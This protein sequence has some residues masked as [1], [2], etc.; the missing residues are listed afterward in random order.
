MGREL[1]TRLEQVRGQDSLPVIVIGKKEFEGNNACLLGEVIGRSF[2]DYD[3]DVEPAFYWSTRRILGFLHI[4][5]KDYAMVSEDRVEQAMEYSTYMPEWPA[6]NSV[7]VWDGMIV[8]KLS[9]FVAE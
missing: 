4:L 1:I 3:T 2:F 7:Q 5:G 9:H 8:V 6:E